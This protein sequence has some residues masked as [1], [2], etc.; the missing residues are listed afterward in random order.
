M[1]IKPG[2]V[3]KG[4]SSSPYMVM[5]SKLKEDEVHCDAQDEREIKNRRLQREANYKNIVVF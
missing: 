5:Q 2:D 1:I 4:S 3:F